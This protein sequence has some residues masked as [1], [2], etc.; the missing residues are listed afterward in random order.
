M[1]ALRLVVTG[2]LLNL[3]LSVSMSQAAAPL[4]VKGKAVMVDA[5][6]SCHASFVRRFRARRRL[7]RARVMPAVVPG[8]PWD[9][10]QQVAFTLPARATEP[11]PVASAPPD[12]PPA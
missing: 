4:V 2:F 8:S 10:P 5:A 3:A 1:R 11:H 7:E 12:H 6:T 9:R